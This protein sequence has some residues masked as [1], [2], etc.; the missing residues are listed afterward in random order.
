MGSALPGDQE[1]QPCSQ[2]RPC[3]L[4]EGKEEQAASSV[5]V[6]GPDCRPGED[7]VDD[8]EAEGGDQGGLLG[9]TAFLEDGGG[10]ECDD[11]DAAHLLGDHDD[12]GGESCAA[13]AGDGEELSEAADVG[14]LADYSFLDLDLRVDVVEVA[15]SLK[16]MMAQLDE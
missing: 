8:T 14:G 13:D 3:H 6:D 5:G 7:E 1:A 2:E 4:R 15:S 11:V 10:V 12:E 9:G 16:F